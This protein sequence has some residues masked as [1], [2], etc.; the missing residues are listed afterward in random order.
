MPAKNLLD[1]AAVIFDLDGTL[2]D[3]LADLADCYNR[4]LKHHGFP[5]HDKQ[6]YKYFIGDGGRKT[7]E[8]ALPESARNEQTIDACVEM[9]TEDYAANWHNRTREYPGITDMLTNLSQRNIQLAVLSNKN[10]SFTQLLVDHFFPGTEF[11]LV[12]GF[13]PGIPHKP[14]PTGALKIAETLALP[15]QKIA[16]VGD[17]EMDMLT[18][19]AVKMEPVGVRW[20][21]RTEQELLAAGATRLIASPIE[22]L[23][24]IA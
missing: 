18:A 1:V 2:L 11:R 3:T 10:H 12:Q 20:G 21:F 5:T 16:L 22:L 9:Q 19:C 14:D 13:M 4:V 8:R 17:S 6:A 24:Q 7:V 23:T 15:C